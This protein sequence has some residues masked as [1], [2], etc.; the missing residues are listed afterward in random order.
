MDL[1][2]K[3]SEVPS[4]SFANQGFMLHF[5]IE[6]DEVAIMYCGNECKEKHVTTHVQM[7]ILM[8]K[9]FLYNAW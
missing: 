4:Q 2:Y 1:V 5:L 6:F 3:C 9:F 7:K 8:T